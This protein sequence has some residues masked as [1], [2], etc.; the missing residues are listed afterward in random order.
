VEINYFGRLSKS[1]ILDDLFARL[2]LKDFIISD[3][4]LHGT[5]ESPILTYACFERLAVDGVEIEGQFHVASH[6]VRR[7]SDW[8][9]L[10]WQITPAKNAEPPR[11]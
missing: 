5:P 1:D 3:P 11:S 6:F 8:K 9:I 4:R 7:G 10:L 2:C